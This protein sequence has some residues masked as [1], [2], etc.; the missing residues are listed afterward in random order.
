MMDENPRIQKILKIFEPTIFHTAISFC[1][2]RAAMIDV[3]NSGKDVPTATMVKPITISDIPKD[4]AIVTAPSTNIFPQKK[5]PTRPPIMKTIE[6][7]SG[8]F[9]IPV[10]SLSSPR[11][12]V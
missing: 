9:L 2:F 10:S 7:G 12:M 4:R 3:A 8:Y 6:R 1:H 11:L 5:R